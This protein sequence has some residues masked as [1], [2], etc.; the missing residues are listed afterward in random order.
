MQNYR[1]GYENDQRPIRV[2]TNGQ[3][4]HCE[5]SA[6][7]HWIASPRENASGYERCRHAGSNRDIGT[8]EADN[9]GNRD[10]AGKNAGE[11]CQCP[12]DIIWY[13]RHKTKWV[14][15]IEAESED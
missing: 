15:M 11:H 14:Q 1:T 5:Q 6:K 7:I 4:N 12:H 10:G 3:G 8:A 9:G 13:A 2:K